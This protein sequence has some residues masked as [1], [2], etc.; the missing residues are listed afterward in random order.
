M[1]LSAVQSGGTSISTQIAR[2][3]RTQTAQLRGRMIYVFYHVF[4]NEH[5]E[6]IVRD[7]V[8]KLHFSGVYALCDTIFCCLLGPQHDAIAELLQDSGVKFVI[9]KRAATPP[10]VRETSERFTLDAIAPL[11][12]P[13]D[14]FLYLH[15]KGVTRPANM[16]V[17]HWRQFMEFQVMTRAKECLQALDTKD[18]AGCNFRFWDVPITNPAHDSFPLT[19]RGRHFSGNMWW[20]TGRHWLSLPRIIHEDYYGPEMHIGLVP[21]R[22]HLL[23]ETFRDDYHHK[24]PFSLF[25]DAPLSRTSVMRESR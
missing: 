17:L 10:T 11:V 18:C 16:F 9:H 25:V 7:Q 15:S 14:K 23:A 3:V 4:C 12:K 6:A 1:V 21:P 20:C 5:A 13:D 24:V 8:A 19:E 2:E 22:V